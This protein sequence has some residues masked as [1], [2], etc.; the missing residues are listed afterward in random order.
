MSNAANLNLMMKAARRIGRRMLRDFEEVRQLQASVRGPVEFVERAHRRSE[1]AVM[2]ELS[3]A[4]PNYGFRSAF[5][6]DSAGEDPTRAWVVNSMDGAANFGHGIAHWS[7]SVAL[8]YKG[9][10]VAAVIFDPVSNE[11][12]AA[13][14]GDGSWLNGTRIRV[15]ARRNPE[16]MLIA[17]SEPSAG[18]ARKR[19][20]AEF[21][22]LSRCAAVIRC[23]GAPALDLAFVASG[24]IDAAYFPL[25][26]KTA[27][28]AG[29]LLI[30][31]AGGMASSADEGADRESPGVIAAAGSG[32]RDFES[33]VR[34][35]LPQFPNNLTEQAELGRRR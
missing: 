21:E 27:A 23:L 9:E 2:D 24:R 7:V 5:F 6:G 33:L 1:T 32:F 31:E 16:K 18:E 8:E 17:V 35:K 14:K 25:L 11:L 26:S 12:F 30:T 20:Q 28:L 3:A 4:R 29:C 34:R 15:S 10:A 13:E 19:F 22:R